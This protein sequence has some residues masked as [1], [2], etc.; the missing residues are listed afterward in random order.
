MSSSDPYG[1][2][3]PPQPYQQPPQ[4]GY[5]PPCPTNGMAIASLV[6]GILWIYGLGAILALVFGYMAKKQIRERGEGGCGLATAGI[7]LGWI[8]IVGLVLILASS[9]SPP[10]ATP[11]AS[12]RRGSYDP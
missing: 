12:R 10:A 1:Q 3:P 7:V 2:Y 8:G 11:A 4:Y 6:L 9:S 5:G